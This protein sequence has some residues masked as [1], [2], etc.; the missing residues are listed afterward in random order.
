MK[1]I[2][3]Y[4]YEGFVDYEISLVCAEVNMSDKYQL[5]YVAYEKSPI[6]SS[7][8]MSI[9]PNYTVKAALKL[10][11]VEGLII[12]GGEI[13]ILKPQLEEL[14]HKVN[15]ENKLI[16]A[17]CGGPEFLAKVGL[18]NGKKYATSMY[19]ED[20]KEKNEEDP[21]PRDTYIDARVIQEG[22]MITAKG[23]A[24]V[25]FAL[26][27]WEWYNLYD[28]PEEKQECKNMFTPT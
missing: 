25:D 4:I 5:I 12:P 1:N 17:I 16:A 18:L 19:P 8:G 13:R 3:C 6:N 21:F 28:Y 20:Y 11:D 10:S 15:N 26:Q 2:L 27:I 9:N 14:I 24:F 7:A 23:E 22:N